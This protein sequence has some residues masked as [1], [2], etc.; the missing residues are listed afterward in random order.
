MVRVSVSNRVHSQINPWRKRG[1]RNNDPSSIFISP[2]IL[3]TFQAYPPISSPTPSSPHSPSFLSYSFVPFPSL[4]LMLH[5]SSRSCQCQWRHP[6]LFCC[7]CYPP[8]LFSQSPFSSDPLPLPH[9]T[10]SH[11]KLSPCFNASFMVLFA[12]A[13]SISST[14]KPLN[15]H[16]WLLWALPEFTDPLQHLDVLSYFSQSSAF[17]PALSLFFAS[18][19]ALMS[20]SSSSSITPTFVS[21]IQPSLSVHVTFSFPSYPKLNWWQYPILCHKVISHQISE[22]RLCHWNKPIN[23]TPPATDMSKYTRVCAG[24]S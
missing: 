19:I 22:T 18:P 11:N 20:L 8:S 21:C 2:F 23:A 16:H 7:R 13:L 6:F 10:P 14:S 17:T 4:P 12:N 1:W 15:L 9:L 5:A 3:S 24:S